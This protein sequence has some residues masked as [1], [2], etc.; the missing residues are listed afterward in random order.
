MCLLSYTC[1]SSLTINVH[2]LAI[3]LAFT[4]VLAVL[5][6]S[7]RK[8]RNGMPLA[9]S[10]SAAIGAACHRPAHDSEA[11]LLPVKYGVVSVNDQGVGHCSFTSA[12]DVEDPSL[13]SEDARPKYAVPSGIYL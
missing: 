7:L 11:H 3:V 4:V 1:D 13:R 8:F 6:S 12:S 10:C 5:L 9:S 2:S